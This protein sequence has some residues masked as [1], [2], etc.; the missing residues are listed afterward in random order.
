MTE[1]AIHPD[2]INDLKIA[3]KFTQDDLLSNRTG[4]LSE[5]QLYQLRV[6]RRQS[7]LLGLGLTFIFT[8][9]ASLMLYNATP[10]RLF[11]GIGV[12]LC[13]AL[14]LGILGRYWMRLT[15]DIRA[16]Q[17]DI[18]SGELERVVKPVTQRIINYMIRIGQV[19]VI[20]PKDTFKVFEHQTHY[21]LYRTHYTGTLLSA[22]RTP[23]LPTEQ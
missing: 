7:I 3:L 1:Q 2:S 4:Q 5:M 18:I 21:T 20:V 9:I 6:R 17:V 22:E 8:L 12:T 11:I 13:N 16:E 10:I 15:A 14:V 19:E 23:N